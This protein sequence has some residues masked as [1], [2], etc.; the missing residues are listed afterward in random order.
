MFGE[1][2]VSDLI[3]G[4]GEEARHHI[5][6]VIIL[7]VRVVSDWGVVTELVPAEALRGVVTVGKDSCLIGQQR[8]K[9][10]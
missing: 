2:R 4:H 5:V 9:D 6:N 10:Q 7:Q 8:L 3:V 1:F